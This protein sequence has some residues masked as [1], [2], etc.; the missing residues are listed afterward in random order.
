MF[1][2]K[3]LVIKIPDGLGKKFTGFMK[4][5]IDGTPNWLRY[6]LIAV[7][8]GGGAFFLTQRIH[9]SY[10]VE[11][12]QKEI[13]ELNEKCKTTV[14]YDRYVYDVSNVVISTKMLQKQIKTM[15][16]SYERMIDIEIDYLSR[17]HPND[18]TIVQLKVLK[19]DCIFIRETYEKMI[20]HLVDS[21][22]NFNPQS[23]NNR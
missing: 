10:D 8:F 20:G 14:F 13:S 15:F 6:L 5:F 17:N 19:D 16:E 7:V 21:Y 12:V 11:I 2:I 22:E 3:N 23:E 1:D 4:K 18:K 9:M